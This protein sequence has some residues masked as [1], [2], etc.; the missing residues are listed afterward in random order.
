MRILYNKIFLEHDTGMH[1]ENR[2][3]LIACGDLPEAM[4]ENGEDHLGLV[5][6]QEYIETIKKLCKT[7]GHI[8]ADTIVSRRSYEAAVYAVGATLMAARQNDFALVR[9]PG[10]HAHPSRASGFCVFNNVAI[11]ARKLAQEGKKVLIFDFDGH[12]GDGTE[13][14][15]YES[16]DVFY[17]S[18]HQYPAFPGWGN[19]DEIGSGKGKGFTI[20]VPLPPGSGDDLFWKAMEMTLPVVHQF[21]PDVVAVSAGFDAHHADLLLDL[22]LSTTTFYRIGKMLREEFKDVFATL[23]GGYNIDYLPLCIKNFINGFN[24]EPIHSEDSSTDSTIQVT[25]EFEMRMSG[26]MKNLAPYWKI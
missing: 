11:A 1:P 13:K 9:P 2:K 25:H 15:F 3:R 17:W 26:L 18:L 4:I 23:E 14:F 12:L 6:A 19:E 22:R 7:G 20:N 5:H 21:A 10:H 24:N 8:D 16:N